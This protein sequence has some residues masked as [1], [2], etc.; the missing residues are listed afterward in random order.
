MKQG[1]IVYCIKDF[2]SGHYSFI[3]NKAYIIVFIYNDYLAGVAPIGYS[4][5][6]NEKKGMYGEHYWF[7]Y[8]IKD[9]GPLFYDHFVNVKK[10]RKDKI[11]KINGI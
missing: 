11:L 8:G 5:S 1:D 3:K 9:D 4:R 6:E 2:N 10:W 7:A